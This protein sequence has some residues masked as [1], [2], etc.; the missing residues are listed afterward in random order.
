[1]IKNISVNFLL[2]ADGIIL[3]SSSENGLQ[4]SLDV[5]NEFCINWKRDVKGILLS[6]SLTCVKCF[7]LALLSRRWIPLI[8][9]IV[10]WTI[11]TSYIDHFM[12]QH[13]A[14]E[15]SAACL[16]VVFELLPGFF[17]CLQY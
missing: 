8:G 11:Y 5:L 13:T 17:Y 7:L 2:Y 16:S 6:K 12:P 9:Y 3:H 10:V 1:M 4:R 14:F 15:Q